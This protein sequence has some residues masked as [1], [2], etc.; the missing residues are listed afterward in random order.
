MA[1]STTDRGFVIYDQFEDTYGH[2]VT[3]QES[4]HADGDRCW[5]FTHPA[6]AHMNVEQARRVRDALD[7]FISEHE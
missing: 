2:V 6:A 4:S 7:V 1:R 5:I 3:I